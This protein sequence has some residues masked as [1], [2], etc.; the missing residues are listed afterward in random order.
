MVLNVFK[1]FWFSKENQITNE[2]SK[3]LEI[4]NKRLAYELDIALQGTTVDLFAK[5]CNLLNA[6]PLYDI[7][8]LKL[9]EK[10]SR[11]LLRLIDSNSK[12][13]VTYKRLYEICG[14]SEFDEDEDKRWLDFKPKRGEIYYIDLGYHNI[15]SEQC[16][17]RPC[18]IIQNDTGNMFSPNLVVIPLTSRLKRFGKTHVKLTKEDGL[19]ETS[20]VICEQLKSISKRRVYYSGATNRITKLSE[21]KMREVET[22]IEFELGL[23]DLNFNEE[24]AY[25]LVEYMRYLKHDINKKQSKYLIGVYNKIKNELEVYCN[26]FKLDYRSIIENYKNLDRQYA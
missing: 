7:L 2:L 12:G 16:G 13:N 9:N 8:N 17:I 15:D 20:Y 4:I 14:Y 3:E 21:E 22:A 6:Q 18:L 11:D 19:R 10:P 25:A 1:Y 24:T 5:Q 26:K 23:E